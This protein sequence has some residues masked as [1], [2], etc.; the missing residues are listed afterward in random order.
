MNYNVEPTAKIVH[1]R[2]RAAMEVENKQE[3]SLN[4]NLEINNECKYIL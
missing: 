3:I 4:E 2:S 1:C